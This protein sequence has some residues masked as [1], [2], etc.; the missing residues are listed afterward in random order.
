M[1]LLFIFCGLL[2]AA[3]GL[4]GFFVPVIRNADT[5][6]PDHDTLEKVKEPEPAPAA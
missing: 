3:V 2:S 4:I 6:M 1:A 5:L